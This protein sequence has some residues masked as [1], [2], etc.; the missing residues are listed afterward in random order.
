MNGHNKRRRLGDIIK[1]QYDCFVE[2]CSPC[3][4]GKSAYSLQLLDG[5]MPP[6]FNHA[7]KDEKKVKTID[8]RFDFFQKS[9][10]QLLY[11]LIVVQLIAGKKIHYML[12]CL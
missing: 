4:L 6:I 9:D 1:E 2:H 12:K 5:F 3:C 11:L 10:H 8:S 7:D